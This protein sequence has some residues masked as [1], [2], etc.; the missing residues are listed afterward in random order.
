MVYDGCKALD[1]VCDSQ[2]NSELA[3]KPKMLIIDDDSDDLELA[4]IGFERQGF[5]VK[6]HQIRGSQD[7]VDLVNRIVVKHYDVILSDTMVGHFYGPSDVAKAIQSAGK[8]VPYFGWSGTP[9]NEHETNWR[10]AQAKDFMIKPMGMAGYQHLGDR[11]R[12]N[13]GYRCE[14]L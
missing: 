7:L 6:T 13:L 12:S 11:L 5:R 1:G 3:G 10:I 2:L 9:N 8:E 14:K 4:A